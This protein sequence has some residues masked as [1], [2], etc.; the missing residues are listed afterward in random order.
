[1]NGKALHALFAQKWLEVA[2]CE[3]E[4]WDFLEV[5]EQAVWN[6]VADSIAVSFD[7]ALMRSS[8]A[9]RL[10]SAEAIIRQ[11]ARDTY[12]KDMTPKQFADRSGY[13][14]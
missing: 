10:S 5:D 4:P 7:P 3:E 13:D 6:A 2:A 8:I 12:G 11:V 14:S 9:E 1:M